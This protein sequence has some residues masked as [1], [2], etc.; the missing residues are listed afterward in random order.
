MSPV[1]SP[2]VASVASVAFV[3]PPVLVL[4][5]SLPALVEVPVPVPVPVPVV[6]SAVVPVLVSLAVSVDADAVADVATP[7]SP[8]QPLPTQRTSAALAQA[9]EENGES[10]R[11]ASILWRERSFMGVHNPSTRRQPRPSKVVKVCAVR[12][13]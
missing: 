3:D 7:S 6:S 12:M 1:V 4:A 8:A 10:A 11:R 9:R 13:T 5:L 2:V